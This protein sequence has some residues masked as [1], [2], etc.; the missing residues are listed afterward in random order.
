MDLKIPF[1]T[2]DQRLSDPQVLKLPEILEDPNERATATRVLMAGMAA[3]VQTIGDLLDEI[4]EAS[5]EQRRRIADQ[6]REAAGL[7]SFSAVQSA[8]QVDESRQRWKRS[9][10]PRRDAD[11]RAFLVCAASG[12]KVE[13]VSAETGAPEPVRARRWFCPTHRHL[14]DPG[15]MDP[16]TTTLR[17]S[18]TGLL[19][20]PD[21]DADAERES[22]RL[23]REQE[24]QQQRREE[25]QAERAER[26]AE[27]AAL[28]AAQ[29]A[30]DD[31]EFFDPLIVRP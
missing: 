9:A 5:P 14:A 11:G 12:C 10:P 31:R 16:W 15:D 26:I 19:L 23:R 6:A 21:D 25:V 28:T 18:E 4:E 30:Q 20:D 27:R 24:R 1:R 3:G 22:E 8:R 29:R 2:R 17:Y 7:P 13:P